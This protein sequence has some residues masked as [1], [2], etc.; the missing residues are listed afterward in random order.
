MEARDSGEAVFVYNYGS[1]LPAGVPEKFRRST[2][3]HPVYAPG[4]TLLSDDFPKD[5]YHHRGIFWAWRVVKWKGETYDLWTIEGVHHRN[6]AHKSDARRGWLRFE[7]GWFA[8]DR[9]IVKE[10][11]EIVAHPAASGRRDLD[12]TLLFEAVN[13]PVEIS[14]SPD[15]GYSGFGFRFAPREATVIETEAGIEKADTNLVPHPWAQLTATFQGRRAG[16][17]IAIDPSNPGAP[18]GWCLRHYGYL[19]VDFPG[20]ATYTLRPGAPLRLKYRVTLFAE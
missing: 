10:T 6:L 3:L 15:R 13:G 12:F 2:Y 1:Q 8:G 9:R 19:G 5:H 14:G 4:G 11:V 20:L 7:N 17:R 18:N 16:A